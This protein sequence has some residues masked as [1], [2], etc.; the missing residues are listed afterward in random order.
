MSAVLQSA[1]SGYQHVQDTPST[2]WTIPH[3]IGTYAPV[4]DCF[5][6]ID[7]VTTKII[8]AEVTAV[9]NIVAIVEFTIPM[10]GTAYVI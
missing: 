8:P 6:V 7:G 9:S 3:N 4:V 5:V 2:T 10:V 1:V